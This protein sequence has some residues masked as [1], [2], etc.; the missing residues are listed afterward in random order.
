MTVDEEPLVPATPATPAGPQDKAAWRRVLRAR[1]RALYS[2]EQGQARR[3]REALA[4]LQHAAPLLEPLAERPASPGPAR[5]A[6]FSPLALE[7]DVMPLARAARSYGVELLF[8]ADAGGPCLDWVLWDGGAFTASPGTGFGTEPSGPRL[9]A[10]ALRGVDLVLAPA[11]AVDRS[12]TRIG[13]GGGY[14]DRA[15]D[16]AGE[17]PVVVVVHPHEVLAA[18]SLPREATDIPVT[19]ALTADGLLCLGE[20]RNTR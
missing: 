3:R 12:G 16:G 1:R 5:M 9:G 11:L 10:S 13:H 17:V 15:L 4:L 2:G 14:Y 8:P 19:R 6:V 20:E 7:A 18:G